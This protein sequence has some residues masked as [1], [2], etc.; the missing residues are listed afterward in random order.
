MPQVKFVE[1]RLHRRCPQVELDD[2]ISVGTIGLIQA[3]DPFNASRNLGLK[4]LVEH[5]MVARC[6]TTCDTSTRYRE[7]FVVSKNSATL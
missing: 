4:T 2:L 3:V 7:A 1:R 6:S 5:R